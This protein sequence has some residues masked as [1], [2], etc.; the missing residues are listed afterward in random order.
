MLCPDSFSCVIVCLA[1]LLVIW[2]PKIEISSMRDPWLSLPENPSESSTWITLSW[3]YS[4]LFSSHPYHNHQPHQAVLCTKLLFTWFNHV[5]TKFTN[6]V[7]K[8]NKLNCTILWA[9]IPFVSKWFEEHT[10]WTVSSSRKEGKC[11]IFSLTGQGWNDIMSKGGVI[12]K[13]CN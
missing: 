9:A 1:A 7:T 11:N 2:C 6:G 5:S 8:Y 3:L 10:I 13:W 4:F 12:N